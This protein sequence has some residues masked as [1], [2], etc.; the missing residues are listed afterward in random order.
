MDAR[1]LELVG[2]LRASGVRVSPAEVA[3]AVRAVALAGVE[4]RATFRSALRATLVKRA[5]DVAVFEALFAQAHQIVLAHTPA[6]AVA[7]VPALTPE[8]VDLPAGDE[9]LERPVDG[10]QA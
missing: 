3:D 2:L 9:L 10:A 6:D 7:H 1:I 5:R 8:D 4:E